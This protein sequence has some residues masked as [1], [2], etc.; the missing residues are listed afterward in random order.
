MSNR[1]TTRDIEL[2]LQGILFRKKKMTKNY[3]QF[4]TKAFYLMQ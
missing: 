2:R 3:L 1:Y 4:V